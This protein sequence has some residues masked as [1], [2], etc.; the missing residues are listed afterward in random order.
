M[1]AFGHFGGA[2]ARGGWSGTGARGVGGF[3]AHKRGA[4]HG[5]WVECKG[6]SGVAGG[7]GHLGSGTASSRHLSVTVLSAQCSAAAAGAGR[8]RLRPGA[9]ARQ[10]AQLGAQQEPK[11]SVWR[12]RSAALASASFTI[13][14]MLV[15]LAP[16]LSICGRVVG[17]KQVQGQMLVGGG[18]PG[19]QQARCQHPS[20]SCPA[21]PPCPSP[22]SPWLPGAPQ[23]RSPRLLTW[24]LIFSR[25]NTRNTRSR[26][27]LVRCTL[28][29]REMMAMPRR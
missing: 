28:Q 16:W 8:K 11:N 21:T 4:A 25:P 19:D 15:L 20:R 24:T 12:A 27:S 6:I 26:I 17:G 18:R 9:A 22:P 5:W 23:A 13:S 14:A 1:G 29:M 7:T 2:A 10:A 3:K